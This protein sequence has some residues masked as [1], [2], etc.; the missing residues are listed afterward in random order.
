MPPVGFGLSFEAAMR[1]MLTV[2][3][4]KCRPEWSEKEIRHKLEG[5]LKAR[6]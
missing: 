3:H 4:P 2:F 6:Q 5:A 1:L